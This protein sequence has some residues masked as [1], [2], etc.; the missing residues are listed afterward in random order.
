MELTNFNKDK[1]LRRQAPVDLGIYGKVPP[2]ARELED[3]VLGAILL[4]RDAFD[5]ANDILTAESFYTDASQRIFRAMQDLRGKNMP[6]DLMTVV[7]QLKTNEDLE[8]VGGPYY[9][10]KLT[11]TVVSSANIETHARIVLQKFLMRELI[12]VSG[13]VTQ[14][15]YDDSTDVFELLDFAEENMSGLRMNNVRKTFKTLQTVMVDNL[16]HLEDLRHRD[17]EVLTGT[18]TGFP[19]LDK[20]TNGWQNTDLII[21]AARPGTGKTALS[22]SFAKNAAK[23]YLETQ[24]NKCQSVGFFSLEMNDRQLVNRVL[25]AESKVWMWRLQNGRIGDSEMRALYSGAQAMQGHQILIDD[26]GALKV[27][28]F[29]AKARIMK[30]KHNVGLIIV[31]YLQLMKNPEKK[32][33][34]QEISSISQ[35]LKEIAKE[36]NIPV[37]ALAQLNRDIEKDG[38]GREP[39]LSDLRESGAIEQDADMVILLYNPTE[40]E[41][42]QDADLK[43]N[44]YL[45]IAKFRNGDAPARFVGKLIKENQSYEYIVKLDKN[46][47]PVHK[48]WTPVSDLPES[49]L[50]IQKGQMSDGEFEDATF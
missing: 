48:S 29:K 40:A 3:A 18:S 50:F 14:A 47:M 6:I 13:E 26:T 12:R 20:V 24:V 36:L 15:A 45:K 49:K 34:E 27:Q 42:M 37:I 35:T 41:I 21:L 23:Y 43:D 4:E 11:N 32:M 39:Q 46:N 33:R 7:E 8:T 19:D 25:S 22:L 44:F 9:V 16:K 17:T 1:K 5:T 31:D 38:K 30:R 2:Q 10:T 28:E